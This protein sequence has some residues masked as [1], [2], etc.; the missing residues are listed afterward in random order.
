MGNCPGATQYTQEAFFPFTVIIVIIIIIIMFQSLI[1]ESCVR[2]ARNKYSKFSPI[3][4]SADRANVSRVMFKDI[5]SDCVCIVTHR[6][7]P[8]SLSHPNSSY[9]RL[10]R[11]NMETRLFHFVS[12]ITPH[13]TSTHICESLVQNLS[14]ITV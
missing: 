1:K 11:A 9:N 6:D 13:L 10:V 3:W 4:R 5:F 2:D 7:G 8:F 12:R 14:L